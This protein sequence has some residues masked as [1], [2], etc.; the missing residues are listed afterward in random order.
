[1][2]KI[3]IILWLLLTLISCNK[4]TTINDIDK[5][6]NEK[7]IQNNISVEKIDHSNTGWGAGSPLEEKTG[8]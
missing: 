3:I 2:K 6:K 1:M 5:I 4:N 8:R 7:E